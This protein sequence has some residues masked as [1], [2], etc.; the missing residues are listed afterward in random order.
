MM[1]GHTSNFQVRFFVIVWRVVLYDEPFGPIIF[2]GR[3]TGEV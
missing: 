2:E 1:F 3:L